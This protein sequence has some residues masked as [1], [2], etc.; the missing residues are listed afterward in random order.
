[1]GRNADVMPCPWSREAP[2]QLEIQTQRF[3][4]LLAQGPRSK[5]HSEC[6]F[7]PSCAVGRGLARRFCL[8][9]NKRPAPIQPSAPVA[10]KRKGDDAR[11]SAKDGP[12]QGSDA[13][14]ELVGQAS[15]STEEHLKR[16]QGKEWRKRCPRCRCLIQD[17]SIP[18]NNP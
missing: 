6:P 5:V 10:K 14:E 18:R 7:M 8:P 9:Q 4:S 11:L 15:E 12:N 13:D 1:M 16:H 3:G 17:P 2:V